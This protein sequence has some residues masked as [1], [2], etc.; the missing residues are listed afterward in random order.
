MEALAHT[1]VTFST[2]DDVVTYLKGQHRQIR[3][4]FDEVSSS[5]GKAQATAFLALRGMLA[6]HEAAE[7]AIIH[8][9]ARIKL[10]D[11]GAIVD[12]RLSEES[13]CR[14][15]L[16]ALEEMDLGAPIF[17]E[18]LQRLKDNVSA[19]AAA[20]E[21]EEFA[22]LVNIIDPVWLVRM[23]MAAEMAEAVAPTR[24]PSATEDRAPFLFGSFLAMLGR[25]KDALSA[26][27]TTVNPS[28]APVHA[29]GPTPTSP[30]S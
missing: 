19:H 7:E 16:A 28:S 24:A 21:R 12:K 3:T 6:I 25:A 29:Q 20:E 23:R 17:T 2:G 27:L 14:L 5:S 10:T 8:P 18:N 1:A 9:I 26:A 30:R 15:T 4:M 13:Q 11:G 22:M